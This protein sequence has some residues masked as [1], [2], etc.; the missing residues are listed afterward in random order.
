[1]DWLKVLGAVYI[2]IVVIVKVTV[3]FSLTVIVAVTCSNDV[4]VGVVVGGGVIIVCSSIIKLGSE[5][6]TLLITSCGKLY[7]QTN[8]LTNTLLRPRY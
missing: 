4:G 3:S 2:V 8:P 5:V 1:M 7:E 6:F